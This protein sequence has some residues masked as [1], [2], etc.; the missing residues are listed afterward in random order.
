MKLAK[1]D[2]RS[3]K[4]RS[5]S[6]VNAAAG[7]LL[8]ALAAFAAA[9]EAEAHV[10]N[11]HAGTTHTDSFSIYRRGHQL[12]N[13]RIVSRPASGDTYWPGETVTVLVPWGWANQASISVNSVGTVH[14]VLSVGSTTRTLTGRWEDRER[15]YGLGNTSFRRLYFDYVVRKGDRDSDGVSLAENALNSP[16]RA[17][18]GIRGTS[19]SSFRQFELQKLLHGFGNQAGHKVDTPAP[20][21]SGVSG[22][23]VTLYT[24][25]SVNYRLPKIANADEAYNVS[26]SVTPALPTGL[27]LNTSTAAITGSHSSEAARGNYTL[28]ATDGF[29]RT[30]DLAFTL[31]VSTD[32]G[33]GVDLDHLESRHGQDLW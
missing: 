2:P 17:E 12:D 28:R 9:P 16:G 27:A 22:P 8:A 20:S 4:S 14:L 6:A 33:I 1:M 19:G 23:T 5:I 11:S 32:V 30:A 31:A 25:G 29:G 15:R 10:G 26:Y 18:S 24:G 21:F 7:L 3:A 13:P